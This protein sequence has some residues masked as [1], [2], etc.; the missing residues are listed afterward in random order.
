MNKNTRD[1]IYLTVI[2]PAYNEENRIKTTLEHI[3]DYIR[4]KDFKVEVIVVDDGSSDYTYEVV[5]EI[6]KSNDFPIK[7]FGND[8][9][10]GKGFTVKKGVL[11]SNGRFIL[12]SDADM[13]T[14]IEEFDKMLPLLEKEYDIV[15]GSRAMYESDIQKRQVWYRE[16]MGKIF[17]FFVQLLVFRGI[18]DTQCG[19]K[20]FK[21]DNAK[22]IFSKVT[23]NRFG[24]DVELLYLAKK[25]QLK[26]TEVPIVWINSPAS[27]VRCF[28]DSLLMFM[29]LI[30]IRMNELLGYYRNI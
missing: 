24:F 20:A 25:M 3:F 7:T 6:S 8:K 10:M 1:E 28:S 26:I 22:R 17:N 27:R 14:P 15:I 21:G 11:Q 13:S 4:G 16:G 5:E 18:K 19:F 30:K 23:I 2:L 29:S 9:N 12:F